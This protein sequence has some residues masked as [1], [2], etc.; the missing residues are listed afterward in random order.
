[1]ITSNIFSCHDAVRNE[2]EYRKAFGSFI[3]KWIESDF[4]ENK[5]TKND[6][7]AILLASKEGMLT[8]SIEY[9]IDN[10]VQRTYREKDTGHPTCGYGDR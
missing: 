1:M 4:D 9:S 3:N 6:Y 8:N 2:R 10:K 5:I 7:Q